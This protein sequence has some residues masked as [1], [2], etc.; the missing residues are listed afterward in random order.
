MKRFTTFA[1]TELYSQSRHSRRNLSSTLFYCVRLYCASFEN[2]SI[3]FQLNELLLF[4]W[5]ETLNFSW[6]KLF[7][8]ECA[9]A[10]DN[11]SMQ[12][13][14][15]FMPLLLLS[16]ERN[17]HKNTNNRTEQFV[18]VLLLSSI[19]TNVCECLVS[20][21]AYF[22]LLRRASPLMALRKR[23]TVKVCVDVSVSVSVCVCASW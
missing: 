10:L 4:A 16:T 21:A 19:K 3:K 15:T 9:T 1:F 12:L 7:N 11:G 20:A 8:N 6:R 22:V 13:E 17:F 14:H 23:N 18:C 5:A 2:V